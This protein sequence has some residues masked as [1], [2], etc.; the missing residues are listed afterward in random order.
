[1]LAASGLLVLR[2]A[3]FGSE[4]AGEVLGGEGFVSCACLRAFSTI[5]A[6]FVSSLARIGTK[7]VGTGVLSL[8]LRANFLRSFSFTALFSRAIVLCR[9]DKRSFSDAENALNESSRSCSTLVVASCG[10]ATLRGGMAAIVTLDVGFFCDCSGAGST[11]AA[12]LASAEAV[13]S[14]GAAGCEGTVAGA[15]GTGVDALGVSAAGLAV[16]C[17]TFAAAESGRAIV[18]DNIAGSIGA[19]WTVA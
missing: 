17:A 19:S 9:S 18:D 4:T 6:C 11:T 1:M 3:A 10:F 14:F 15:D 8:K 2:A 5:A 7:S 12:G 16:R 13:A